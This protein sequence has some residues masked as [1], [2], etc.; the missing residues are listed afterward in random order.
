MVAG[1]TH[2]NLIFDCVTPA[3][4]EMDEADLK[5]SIKQAVRSSRPDYF[6]VITVESSYASIPH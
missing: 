2:T 1:P 4:F 6:C 3:D 5:Q